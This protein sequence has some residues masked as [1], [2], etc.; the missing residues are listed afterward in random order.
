MFPVFNQL[1]ALSDGET[2][3]SGV[4]A[5]AQYLAPK[6]L[7]G[8]VLVDEVQVLQWLNMAEHELLPAVMALGDSSAAAKQSQPRAREELFSILDAL[9]KILLTRTYLVGEAITLA[10]IFVACTLVPA[11]QRSLDASARAKY[12]NVL[13]WFNTITPQPNVKQVLGEV[14]LLGKSTK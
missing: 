11:L 7:K 10:D 1:P 8:S 6:A 2:K 14:A 9:N 4:I 5:I 3:L 13:R 12:C